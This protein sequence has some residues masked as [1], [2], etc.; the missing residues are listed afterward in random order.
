MTVEQYS[1]NLAHG[2]IKFHDGPD[3]RFWPRLTARLNT[4]SFK[5]TL[6]PCCSAAWPEPSCNAAWL[7]PS[8][9]LGTL[10]LGLSLAA[11]QLGSDQAANFNCNCNSDQLQKI[12]FER[13][14]L[15]FEGR[16]ELCPWRKTGIVD[17]PGQ[18]S[19]RPSTT[20]RQI[21]SNRINMDERKEKASRQN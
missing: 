2:I 18:Q 12:V 3:L 15:G 11:L 9:I 13:H 6:I 17:F 19:R 21:G 16:L 1:A 4:P 14:L 8:Y 10:Q 20:S 7:D 5:Y